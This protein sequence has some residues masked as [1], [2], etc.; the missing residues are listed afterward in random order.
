MLKVFLN[1]VIS[2][3]L[4]KLRSFALETV[5]KLN[6]ETL[7]NEEKREAAFK[8]IRQ[9]AINEGKNLRDSLINLALE[10]AVNWL[11]K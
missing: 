6:S 1:I 9:E 2:M 8:A 11:K 10:A 3:I 5:E 7:T 4:G